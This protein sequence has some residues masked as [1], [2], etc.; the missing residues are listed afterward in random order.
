MR[1]DQQYRAEEL[2]QRFHKSWPPRSFLARLDPGT[3]GALAVGRYGARFDAGETLIREGDTTTDVFMLMSAQVKVTAQLERGMALLAVRVGGDIVGEMAAA[4]GG[5]RSATVTATRDDTMAIAVSA[6]EFVGA[7]SR[8]PEASRLLA[9]DLTRKLRAANRRRADFTA[10]QVPV[11]VARVLGEMAEEYG[12]SVDRK[13]SVRVLRVGLSQGELA[14][15]VGAREAS[16]AAALRDMRARGILEWGYR[17]VT[18]RD[19]EALRAAG[20]PP[21]CGKEIP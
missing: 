12:Q 9:S 18:I 5:P 4:D 10:Y 13:P 15:L 11:R 2:V 6:E 19:I 8:H 16:V 21:P 7:V 20:H 1:R 14:T 17:T 3:L